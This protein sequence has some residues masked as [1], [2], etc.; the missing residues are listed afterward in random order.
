MILKE[1]KGFY[2]PFCGLLEGLKFLQIL[3]TFCTFG[4]NP[5]ERGEQF[6]PRDAV[7]AGHGNSGLYQTR[8]IAP[9]GAL[10]AKTPRC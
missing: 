8:E 7:F 1:V 2:A 3:G 10:G 4:A 9:G 6:V 5:L